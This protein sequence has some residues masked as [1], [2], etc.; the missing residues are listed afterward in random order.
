MILA[1]QMDKSEHGEKNHVRVCASV[2]N[3]F[4]SCE[5]LEASEFLKNA[6]GVKNEKC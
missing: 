3:Q 1:P 5:K 6:N 2:A 4:A